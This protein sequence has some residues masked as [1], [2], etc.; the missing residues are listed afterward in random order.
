LEVLTLVS[1]IV[2]TN[3]LTL[4]DI[5]GFKSAAISAGINRAMSLG[6]ARA[7]TELVVRQALP[8][9]DFGAPAGYVLEEYRNQAMGAGAWTL[10]FDGGA[11]PVLANNRLAVFY[12]FANYSLAPTMPAIRF[13]IGPTGASTKATFH[14]QLDTGSKIEPDVYFT[15]PVIYDPQDTLFIE[16]YSTV[17]VGALGEAFAFGVFIVERL[18]AVIS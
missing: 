1:Y 2:P 4:S 3:E 7:E 13:R 12:K 8:F 14:M 11:A 15:E 18:G 17:G 6:L 5:K 10:L 9:T 16:G